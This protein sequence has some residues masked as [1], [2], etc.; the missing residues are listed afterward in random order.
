MGSVSR[1]NGIRRSGARVLALPSEARARG[2]IAHQP[3]RGVLSLA[4]CIEC[5][6][7]AGTHLALIRSFDRRRAAFR[8][9]SA[10]LKVP[11][12]RRVGGAPARNARPIRGGANRCRTAC[13]ACSAS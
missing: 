1:A 8:G 6:N 9:C 3:T 2:S 10:I 7:S 13:G 4:R 12:G 11:G 5:R